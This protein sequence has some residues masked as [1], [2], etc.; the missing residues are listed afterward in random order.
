MTREWLPFDMA[1]TRFGYNH[2]ESLRNRIRQLRERELVVDTGNPP[3]EYQI[4]DSTT[5][6]KVVLL[7][8]NPK[9]A[10]VRSDAPVRLLNPKRGKRAKRVL[11]VD[12]EH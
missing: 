2:K 9:T 11:D 12:K 6:K 1:A 10:L 3:A 5:R 7:W 4:G 8:A